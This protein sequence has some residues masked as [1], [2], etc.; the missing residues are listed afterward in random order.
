M[1]CSHMQNGQIAYV[2]KC[3]DVCALNVGGW[4]REGCLATCGVQGYVGGIGW[5]LF[6]DSEVESKLEGT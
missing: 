6:L 4:S 5:G 3:V 2:S 1:P